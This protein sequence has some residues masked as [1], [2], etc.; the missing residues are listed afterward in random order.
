MSGSYSTTPNLGLK[1]PLTGADDDLWGTHW[2]QNADI[3]DVSLS[4]MRWGILPLAGNTPPASGGTGYAVGDVITLTGGATV[5]VITATGGSVTEFQVQQSGSYTAVPTGSLSQTATTGT[6][7]G[8]VV[9]PPFGPIAATIGAMPLSSGSAFQG[10]F[11]LGAGAGSALTIGAEETFIG[12]YA[13]FTVTS[14]H[15]NS[16]F[17]H[18]ALG[19]ETTGA[20]NTAIGNDSQRNTRGSNSGSSLGANALR[21]SNGNWN[22]AVGGSAMYGNE[23]GGTLGN[24]NTAVGFEA[25]KG[26]SATTANNNT[27]VGYQAGFN[28]TT[29]ANNTFLGLNAGAGLTTGTYNTIIGTGV[30]GNLVSGQGNIV[31]GTSSFAQTPAVDTS[32][33]LIIQGNG[34]VPVISAVNIQTATPTVTMPGDVHAGGGLF[35]QS[36]VQVGNTG[37][38]SPGSIVL[39][40]AVSESKMMLTYRG[41]SLAWAMIVGGGTDDLW[42]ESRDNA[43]ANV[44]V[45]LSIARLSGMITMPKLAASTSYANDAAAGAAGVAVGTLYRNGSAVMVRVV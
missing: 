2:N 34:S 7:T 19:F 5:S 44:G 40:G 38:G 22:T 9:T 23:A 14:G 4:A 41:G 39:A 25:L 10:N 6:G 35:S 43:G 36:L 30:S 29:A 26:M 28:V 31:I 11:V 16:A 21:N 32:N 42:F 12:A 15:Y 13:G 24:A 3:L 27:A 18:R 45:A 37:G 20:L 33:M 8:F 17:G 1:K